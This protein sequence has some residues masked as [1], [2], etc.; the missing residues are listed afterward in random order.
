ILER[1]VRHALV[2]AGI[3]RQAAHRPYEERVSIGRRLGH[4]VRA[5]VT[6]APSAVVDDDLRPQTLREPLRSDPRNDVRATPRREG[7]DHP[8][9]LAGETLCTG[10]HAPRDAEAGYYVEY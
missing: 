2:K 5:D 9:R 3:D 6:A 8:H 4:E 10:R 7:H 1:I